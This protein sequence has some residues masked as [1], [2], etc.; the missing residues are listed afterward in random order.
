[1]A[2]AGHCVV[3]KRTLWARGPNVEVYICP[4]SAGPFPGPLKGVDRRLTSVLEVGPMSK[5]NRPICPTN[6]GA[7]LAWELH[8]GGRSNGP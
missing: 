4:L 1:M 6:F 3:Y 5:D 7:R 2:H 8:T